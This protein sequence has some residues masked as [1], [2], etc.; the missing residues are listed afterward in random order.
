[1]GQRLRDFINGLIRNI[2]ATLKGDAES[3][4]QYVTVKEVLDAS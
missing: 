3:N 2:L 4:S 1:M